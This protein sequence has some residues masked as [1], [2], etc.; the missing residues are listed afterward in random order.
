VKAKEST[1]W[2]ELAKRWRDAG[3]SFKTRDGNL[4]HGI[5][6]ALDELLG[7]P[8]HRRADARLTAYLAKRNLTYWIYPT[9]NPHNRQGSKKWSKRYDNLRAKICDKLAAEAKK[10]GK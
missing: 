10:E 5:C 1:Y 9:F 7:S 2:T 4:Q 6:F 3:M 8:L